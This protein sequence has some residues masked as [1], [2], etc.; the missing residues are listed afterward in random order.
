M[1]VLLTFFETKKKEKHKIY[2]LIEGPSRGSENE[3]TK[4]LNNV[5]HFVSA[6]VRAHTHTHTH[7][8]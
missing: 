8:G 5:N 6:H 4:E 2:K 3:E 7:T 1:C